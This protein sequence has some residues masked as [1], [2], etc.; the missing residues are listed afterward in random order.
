M[1]QRQGAENCIPSDRRHQQPGNI[2]LGEMPFSLVL[3]P[4][5]PHR[6]SSMMGWSKV[7][8]LP[9]WSRQ[10]HPPACGADAAAPAA[11]PGWRWVINYRGQ[12]MA[13]KTTGGNTAD[14]CQP[15]QPRIAA[16]R[17]KVV[18]NRE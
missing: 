13:V 7:P 8:L 16:L 15:L 4:L 11:A 2:S 1:E 14:T 17:G 12:S 18:G 10:H 5:S 6:T 9:C 3:F